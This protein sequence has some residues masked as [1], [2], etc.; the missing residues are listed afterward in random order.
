MYRWPAPSILKLTR[1]CRSTIL[2]ENKEEK[3]KPE[4][5]LSAALC[6]DEGS[7]TG[8]N[9][10]PWSL[11]WPGN[12]A[13][14][15]RGGEAGRE[16][17]AT[18]PSRTWSSWCLWKAPSHQAWWVMRR[19]H[20]PSA[21]ERERLEKS[22]NP[23]AR[24]LWRAPPPT[25]GSTCAPRLPG[26]SLFVWRGRKETGSLGCWFCTLQSPFTGEFNT[27]DKECGSHGFC[28]CCSCPAWAGF[29]L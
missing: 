14:E 3:G 4:R 26:L 11:S 13:G 7:G 23:Q 21:P 6:C 12:K 17:P 19:I 28:R 16:G 20:T 9:V 24:L 25:P 27:L 10:H 8:A 5:L 1:H 2:P 29:C 18:M 15:C 22:T